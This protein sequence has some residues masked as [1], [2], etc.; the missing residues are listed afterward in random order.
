VEWLTDLCNL[1]GRLWLGG[2]MVRAVGS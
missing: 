1:E 2:V